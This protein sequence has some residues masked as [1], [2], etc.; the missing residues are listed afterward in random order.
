[1]LIYINIH[2]AP[3][4]TRKKGQQVFLT[5]KTLPQSGLKLLNL[6]PHSL[7][8]VGNAFACCLLACLPAACLLACLFVCLLACLLACCLPACLLACCLPACLLA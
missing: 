3:M 7:S 4:E 1:M 2:A 6:L 5:A 8:C